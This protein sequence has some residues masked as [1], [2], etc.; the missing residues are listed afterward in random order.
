[1]RLLNLQINMVIFMNN[2]KVGFIGAGKVGV[3]LGAYFLSKGLRIG[4]YMSRSLQSA[5]NAAE[6]T[7]SQLYGNMEELVD[8]CGIIIITAPDGQIGEIWKELACCCSIKGKIICHTS[9]SL[10]SDIFTGINECEASGYSIHPMYAF[11]NRDG[12]I[13]GL[14]KAYFTIE[15]LQHRMNDIKE[16]FLLLG[17]RTIIIEPE[18]KS[19]YHLSNV[20]VSNL[21]LSLISIGC[22]CFENCGTDGQEAI[23][24]LMPL[25]T[26]NI[27]NIQRQ[28][29]IDSITG[30]VERNDSGTVSKHLEVLP[31]RYERIY[32]DLSLRLAGLSA[33]K[34]PERDY[35]ELLKLLIGP[36]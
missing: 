23:S 14:E 19:L 26:G 20:L 7:S 18:S 32:R 2:I 30:P 27:G 24:A 8:K 4:G 5:R 34:Y 11:S 21:V 28:G 36:V 33:Q 15:G 16:L 10:S 13:E 29:I 9:G 3:S 35:S 17:N 22:E 1:M 6:I 31:A 25:I 12:R